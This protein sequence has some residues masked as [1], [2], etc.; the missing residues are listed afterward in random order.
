MEVLSLDSTY[1]SV[2]VAYFTLQTCSCI[3][4]DI[5]RKCFLAFYPYEVV[6]AAFKALQLCFL[7]QTP[8][9]CTLLNIMRC[10]TIFYKGRSTIFLVYLSSRQS[11]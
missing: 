5:F 11:S 1:S 2:A 8:F 9:K 3:A 4:I 7:F 6:L 10:L